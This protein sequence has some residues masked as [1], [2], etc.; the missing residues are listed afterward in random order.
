[1]TSPRLARIESVEYVN[2]FPSDFGDA[3][4]KL[5]AY[6]YIFDDRIEGTANHKAAP[7]WGPGDEV[8]YTITGEHRGVNKLKVAKPGSG[9]P[10][11]AQG[12]A[13]ARSAA[14]TRSAP[15]PARQNAPRE[16]GS[17][18]GVTVGMAV[19]NGVSIALAQSEDPNAGL[20]PGSLD[21]FNEVY[22]HASRLLRMS[23]TLESGKLAP[24]P[25]TQPDREPEPEPE[26]EP[27]PEPTPAPRRQERP[28]PGPG[29]SVAHNPDDEDVPF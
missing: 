12:R 1:M 10:P 16:A 13:P 29:G 20:L 28:Q 3:N 25:T 5:H 24:K 23:A 19:N 21:F 11:A 6:H 15:S 7:S 4:G 17:Y 8:E 2:S 18:L 22:H 26:P 27:D 9:R 14:P